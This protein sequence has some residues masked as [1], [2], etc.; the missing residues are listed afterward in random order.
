MAKLAGPGGIN[1]QGK[2]G[3]FTF[4]QLNGQ[5]IMRRLPSSHRNRTHPSPLQQLYRQ[6]FKEINAFLNPFKKVLNFGFQNQCTQSKRGTHCAYRELV[7]KGY[8]FGKEPRIDPAYLKISSGSLLEPEEVG[9]SRNDLSISLT[10]R[11][12]DNQ[13]SSFRRSRVMFFLLHPETGNYYWFPE[14]GFSDQLALS[15]KIKETDLDRNWCAFLAFYRKGSGGK[16][17]FS[18]SVYA[19]RI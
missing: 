9:I 4:Y 11:D 7:Q 10:W 18:D 5:T 3:G 1:P 16:Y 2:T 17:E 13:G 12:Q 8:S 6:R 19:G 14:A 15:I